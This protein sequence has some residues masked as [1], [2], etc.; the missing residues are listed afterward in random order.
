[1]TIEYVNFL[2][3]MKDLTIDLRNIY[4]HRNYQ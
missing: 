1:L 2:V 4:S 3:L